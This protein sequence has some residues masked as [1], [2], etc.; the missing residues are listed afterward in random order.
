MGSSPDQTICAAT[1]RNLTLLFCDQ[2]TSIRNASSDEIWNRSIRIP[3]AC[4]IYIPTR[5]RDAKG[6]RPS[7]SEQAQRGDSSPRHTRMRR[8]GEPHHSGMKQTPQEC[9]DI[10]CSLCL[11]QGG[12]QPLR[13]AD[14]RYV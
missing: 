1:A 9:S 2:W 10:R 3:F 13:R 4:P 7:I 14:R 8:P 5:Q 6:G 11:L 12:G